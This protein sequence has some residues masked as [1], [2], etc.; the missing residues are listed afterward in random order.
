MGGLLF[1]FDAPSV[2]GGISIGLGALYILASPSGFIES[3]KND[4]TQNIRFR[5]DVI[6][7]G[8][9][10]TTPAI[11]GR[12]QT[13]QTNLSG[14]DRAIHRASNDL[15]RALP[16]NSRIAVLSVSS[17]NENLSAYVIDAIEFHLV[18]A[19]RFIVVDRV[20]LDAVRSEQNLHMSGDISDASAISIGHMLGA[21]IV[22]TG[23]IF[24]IGT[25]QSLSIRAL[26]VTTAQIITMVREAF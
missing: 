13:T 16:G 26:D 12:T 18:T 4:P 10:A 19:R 11:A 8:R 5:A 7:Y 25:N 22:I 15:I 6:A 3:R 9:A 24:E 17:N 23:S 14:I 2:L 1:Y 21:S 20:T